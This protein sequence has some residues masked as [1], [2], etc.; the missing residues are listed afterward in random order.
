M[1]GT[2][3]RGSFAIPLTLSG[4]EPRGEAPGNGRPRA[5]AGRAPRDREHVPGALPDASVAAR[6]SRGRP[7]EA[8]RRR[9]L[10]RF[11]CEAAPAGTSREVP[12]RPRRGARSGTASLRR[13]RQSLD[14][15]EDPDRGRRQVLVPRDARRRRAR[16][17]R[18]RPARRGDDVLGRRDPRR[19]GEERRGARRNHRAATDG[20]HQRALDHEA[21]ETGHASGARHMG[22]RR[23]RGTAPHR[24]ANHRRAGEGATP[25]DGRARPDSRGGGRAPQPDAL[26][27]PRQWGSRRRPGRWRPGARACHGRRRPR[28]AGRRDGARARGGLGRR[29]EGRG[30]RLRGRPLRGVPAAAGGARARRGCLGRSREERI[31]PARR[32]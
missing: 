5:L 19:P 8:L 27:L 29:D 26:R 1:L 13:G 4:A 6:R 30:R 23:R 14:A 20:S 21:P 28:R 17:T 12:P 25:R 2:P 31:R 11:A 22:R 3:N 32:S 16:P 7:R 24:G 18:A 9:S 10:G 15:G